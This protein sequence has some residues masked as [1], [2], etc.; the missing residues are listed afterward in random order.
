MAQFNWERIPEWSSK[1]TFSGE[2]R[3]IEAFTTD[4]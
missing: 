4:Q 3:V 1:R 2:Q